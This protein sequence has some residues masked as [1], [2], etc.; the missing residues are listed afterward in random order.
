VKAVR[1]LAWLALVLAPAG[2]AASDDQGGQGFGVP[3]QAFSAVRERLLVQI[4]AEDA[5]R[6]PGA[7]A[8]QDL[9]GTRTVLV[10][11]GE[12]AAP[13]RDVTV[14][15]AAAWGR[16]PEELFRTGLAN[17]ERR[18]PPQVRATPELARG[19]R[20]N[21][22]YG[23]HPFAAAY[24]LWVADDKRCRGS[25]G[26]LVSIPNQHAVLCH[27]VESSRALH[28]YLALVTMGADIVR[29]GENPIVPHVFWH[30]D[31]VFEAQP[32]RIVGEMMRPERTEAFEAVLERL[33]RDIHDREGRR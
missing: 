29:G 24:V 19:V 31:G 2:P 13:D 28:A 15:E 5:P 1:A 4:R 18:H 21:L 12:G 11:P 16:T 22:F 8:R 14:E 17:L 32:V 10:L 26:A 3:S 7:V 6:A 20:L 27:P 9:L 25:E 23:E 33:P 30:H